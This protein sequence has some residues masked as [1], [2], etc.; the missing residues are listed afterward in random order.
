MSYILEA[1]KELDL[2]ENIRA[3]KSAI[4]SYMVVLLT[5]MLKCIYQPEYKNKSSW[6]GS[7]LNSRSGIESNIGTIGKGVMYKKFYMQ[8]LDLD[9][10]YSDAVLIAA[11]ETGKPLNVFPST[12]PWSREQLIDRI[13]IQEFIEKYCINN[14]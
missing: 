13:F 5:H 8:E 2:M 3:S 11:S 4:Q 12:C 6:T 9:G 14:K 7:I 10:L 1:L